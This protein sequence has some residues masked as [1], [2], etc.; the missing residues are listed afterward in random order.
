VLR[1]VVIAAI[2]ATCACAPALAKTTTAVKCSTKGLTSGKAKITEVQTDGMSCTKAVAVARKVAAD[3][4]NNRAVSVPGVSGFAMSTDSCIGCGGT[5]TKVGL[6]YASGAKLTISIRGGGSGITINPGPTLP[7]PSIP[8]P[9]SG[10]S[11]P[12]TV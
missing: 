2:G 9:G 4:V 5:T 1:A 10:G 6:T 12:I 11:G 8:S 7:T 3:V